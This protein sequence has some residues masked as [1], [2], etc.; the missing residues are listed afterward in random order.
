VLVNVSGAGSS[1]RIDGDG[2]SGYLRLAAGAG[3]AAMYIS[4]GARLDAAISSLHIGL[5]TGRGA[6]TVQGAGSVADVRSAYVYVGDPIQA[7]PAGSGWLHVTQGGLLRAREL[8]ISPKG[9]LS[10]SG[11]IV[12]DAI[13]N[14][15]TISP[16][17]SPGTL[18]LEGQWRNEVGARLVLEVEDDGQGGYLT[19][20][21]LLSQLPDL[22]GLDIEFRF[23]GRTDPLAFL[24]TGLFDIDQFVSV[25]G[26]PLSDDAYAAVR[27]TASSDAFSIRDF[28][29]AAAGGA[30]FTAAQIPLPG[31]LALVLLGLVGLAGPRGRRR[32]A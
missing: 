32:R 18:R 9:L 30:S 10:G 11:T 28:V 26:T 1:W 15:G 16:G 17:D 21:L 27:F 7:D 31:S 13:I 25:D 6:L 14:R 12:A 5:G 24:A 23:L 22:Q 2:N 19:D 8:T 4:D 3:N 20:Q 29:Y